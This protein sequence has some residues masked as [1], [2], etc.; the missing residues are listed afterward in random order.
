VRILGIAMGGFLP[1][2]CIPSYLTNS[3]FCYAGP[4]AWNSLSHHLHQINDIG[5]FK[6]RLK[7]ELF[8]RAR[9]Y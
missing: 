3:G 6:R 8:R 4:V 1:I 9:H 7:T 5:L 2:G